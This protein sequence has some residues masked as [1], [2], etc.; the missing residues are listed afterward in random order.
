MG[1][2]L[3]LRQA[4]YISVMASRNYQLFREAILSERQIVCLQGGHRREV[5]PHI[6]GLNKAGEEVVLTW[7]FA[8]G[9]N[10]R[11][12]LGGAWRCFKLAGVSQ[13]ELR[14]G[15]WRAGEGH[16]REQTCVVVIDLDINVHV[17]KLR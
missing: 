9:S 5:C 3:F 10:G 17:R 6:I 1:R 16:Q 12:P 8:G 4:A 15:P 7:Q 11:L 13:I 14:E 2:P